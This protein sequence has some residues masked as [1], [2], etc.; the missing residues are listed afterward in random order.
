[1]TMERKRE[2]KFGFTGHVVQTELLILLAGQLV[3]DQIAW[4]QKT[5]SKKC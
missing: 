3:K 5:G 1:M 2:K 4:L